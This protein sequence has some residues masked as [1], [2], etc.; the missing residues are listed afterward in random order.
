[1]RRFPTCKYQLQCYYQ[2]YRT[3][4]ALGN[5][6]RSEYYKNI[7][8]NEHGNTEYAEIIRNPNYLTEKANEKSNLDIFYE[9]TYRKYLNGE[10]AAV[11]ARKTD[12]DVQFP[13]NIL[14]PK[15][16]MLKTLSIGRTQPLPVFEDLAPEVAFLC[17]P[18][19][20]CLNCE[21]A[22]LETARDLL[23]GHRRRSL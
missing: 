15:F 3:Y 21:V 10:Y 22:N 17:Q 7:I 13:Q 12:A 1:M 5:T 9:E 16:D 14:T 6:E 19:R 8:L 11:I 2:L 23:P 4:A 18:P 20:H